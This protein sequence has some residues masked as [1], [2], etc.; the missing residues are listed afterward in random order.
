MASS[1][2]RRAD[3][4]AHVVDDLL[5]TGAFVDLFVGSSASSLGSSLGTAA[6]EVD[7]P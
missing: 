3:R 6:R 2:H 4:I 1:C 7:Q 5:L